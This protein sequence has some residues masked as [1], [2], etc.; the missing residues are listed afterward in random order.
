MID[1][2]YDTLTDILS[3]TKRY[4]MKILRWPHLNSQRSRIRC[5]WRKSLCCTRHTTWLSPSLTLKIQN[6]QHPPANQ[7]THFSL[8]PTSCVH[9]AHG[10]GYLAHLQRVKNGH[11]RSSQ[12]MRI[13]KHKIKHSKY[14]HLN[15]TSHLILCDIQASHRKHKRYFWSII[16]HMKKLLTTIIST[17]S[18][19]IAYAGFSQAQAAVPSFDKSFT[20]YLTNT[21]IIDPTHGTETVFDLCIDRNVSLMTN[22][23][24]LFYPNSIRPNS[25]CSTSRWGLLRDT[26]RV[27][28]FAVVFIFILLSG[29]KLLTNGNEEGEVKS[30]MRSFMYIFYGAFLILGSTRLLGIDV[31]NVENLGWSWALTENIQWWPDSLFFHILSFFKMLAFFL[32]ILMIVYYW[33]RI[34]QAM[35]EEDKIKTAQKWILNV[36]IAIFFI[37]IVDFVF[38][39]AQTPTLADK[40]T[41]FLINIAKVL[42]YIIGALFIVF[43]FYAG[44]LLLTSGG[45]DDNMTKV[46]NILL[47][48]VLSSLVIFLFILITYQIFAEFT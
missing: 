20:N 30:A 17:I 18:I 35:D 45:K 9:W 39:I 38:Y 32:A 6:I 43:T 47:T 41:D 34:M 5:Q 27:V 19:I 48:I 37:K 22:I 3:R 33:I 7:K 2:Y 42:G 8:P 13:W 40:A 15:T 1:V 36:I 12:F 10:G 11:Y 21:D 31:L 16:H 46:K 4:S 23:K 28:T 29:I 24:N 44:F 14:L 25:K 26:I